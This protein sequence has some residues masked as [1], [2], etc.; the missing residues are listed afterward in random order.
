LRHPVAGFDPDRRY[1]QRQRRIGR[2]ADEV[3]CAQ[4]PAIGGGDIMRRMSFQRRHLGGDAAEGIGEWKFYR[5]DRREAIEQRRKR[6]VERG[7]R[8]RQALGGIMR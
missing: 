4:R 1:R 7:E 3:T 2:G 8:R 6:G 5:R